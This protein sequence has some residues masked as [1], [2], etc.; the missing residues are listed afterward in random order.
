M[1]GS[2]WGLRG[3]E[4]LGG[5]LKAIFTLENGFSI[6]NGTNGQGG[7]E[8]GRQAFV[9]LSS[10]QFGAVTLGRQ[11]DTVV[12]YLGPLA[13]TG[14]QYGGTQFAHPFDNDNLNN[15]FRVNNSVKY[16]S[17]NYAGF[18]F[19]GMYGFS[20]QADGFANNRAYSVGASYNYGPLNVAAAY[21]QLNNNE[22]DACSA[23]RATARSRAT[24]RSPLAVSTRS[25]AVRTTRSA[26]QR[27][28]SCSRKRS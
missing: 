14:T 16:T 11:Y 21:M 9:G 10:D 2:R 19:G 18:K 12:D 3:A 13:L 23:Q 8:F 27:S 4:D 24:T 1:N 5:G 28:A 22:R 20:N 26:R 17:A 6:M 7:R 15:S 25:A